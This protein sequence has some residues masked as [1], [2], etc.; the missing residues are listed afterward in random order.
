MATVYS[1]AF[2]NHV[3]D[4]QIFGSTDIAVVKTV[5]GGNGSV[6]AVARDI[7]AATTIVSA[8][9]GGA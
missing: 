2:L 8:L 3:G 1:A 7:E 4:R 6:I 5:D 9:N